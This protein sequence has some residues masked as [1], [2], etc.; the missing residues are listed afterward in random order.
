MPGCM[1]YCLSFCTPGAPQAKTTNAMCTLTVGKSRMGFLGSESQEEKDTA[2]DET[3]G[4][5]LHWQGCWDGLAH[6]PQEIPA[7]PECPS[8]SLSLPR[9]M[10]VF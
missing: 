2:A 9:L 7:V 10:C 8:L 5:Q 6:A 1:P 3:P 4:C